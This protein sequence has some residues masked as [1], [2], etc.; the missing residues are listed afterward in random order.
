MNEAI[1][2]MG[3]NALVLDTA[4][5]R[6]G[7]EVTAV[8]NRSMGM[9]IANQDDYVKAGEY[10]K[11]IKLMQKKVTEYWEP[12][13]Q[14]TKA[15][16]DD[17][18]AKKKQ[19]LE[20]LM[21]SE[22]TIKARMS[23]YVVAED[24]RRKAREE[25]MRRAAAIEAEKKLAEA[26]A[27]EAAGDTFGAEFAM[28]E[29]EVMEDVAANGTVNTAPVKAKGVSTSKAWRIK[30]IDEDKVPIDV[31][32]YVIR[33]VDEKAIMGLIKATKGKVKIPGI[34]YEEIVNISV[35]A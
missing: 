19:M 25:E 13:R 29:A 31:A 24:R 12:L 6:L 20:P 34:V 30:S 9:V 22:K 4:E 15:A 3:S 10:V 26:A 32:G 14:S 1:P 33:P 21:E 18:I 28:T 23:D 35:R 8:E 11:T 16:Y 27:C 2:V 5:E 17:V 7:K